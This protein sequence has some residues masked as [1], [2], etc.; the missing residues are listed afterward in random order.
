MKKLEQ[1][2]EAKAAAKAANMG[3]SLDGYK[4]A[5]SDVEAFTK[6]RS[7]ASG[8]KDAATGEVRQPR[9]TETAMAEALL[10]DAKARET[11]YYDRIVSLGVGE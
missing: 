1:Y 6:A 4:T 5:L 3:V 11:F 8:E 2:K 10:E 7:N 9:V